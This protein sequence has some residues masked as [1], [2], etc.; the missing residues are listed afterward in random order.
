MKT[1]KFALLVGTL[2]LVGN[3]V[4]PTLV[5]ALETQEGSL[6]IDAGA[7]EIYYNNYDSGSLVGFD[8]V[9]ADGSTLAAS[10]F[11]QDAF[12]AHS[13]DAP[14]ALDAWSPGT[15]LE[16]FIG[17]ADFTD[18]NAAWN[19][20]AQVDTSFAGVTNT[21]TLTNDNF[22]MATASGTWGE[23]VVLTDNES[24]QVE[25]DSLAGD[26]LDKTNDVY[27][28]VDPSSLY[29]PDGADFDADLNVD[30]KTASL[31]AAG[32]YVTGIRTPVDFLEKANVLDPTPGIFG[33]AVNYYHLVAAG[34]PADTY[35]TNVT[36]TLYPA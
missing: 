4:L 8:M 1:K 34:T 29:S 12:S 21:I 14:T 32:T 24:T 30:W 10:A 22:K 17:V 13:A 15:Y 36:Y 18:S 33:V 25:F 3:I 19:L 35:T 27:Y 9:E 20:Q 16:S 5:A 2:F 26:A 6:H 7:K 28:Y 23:S 11:I 31:D